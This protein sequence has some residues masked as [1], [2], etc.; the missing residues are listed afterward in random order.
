MIQMGQCLAYT[1]ERVDTNIK[2]NQE[3]ARETAMIVT[4]EP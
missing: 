3:F 2:N 1:I 4:R